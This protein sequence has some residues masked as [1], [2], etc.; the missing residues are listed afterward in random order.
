MTDSSALDK[1]HDLEWGLVLFFYVSTLIS[2]EF[3]KK[4]FCRYLN[5]FIE[6]SPNPAGLGSWSLGGDFAYLVLTGLT[7]GRTIFLP[8]FLVLGEHILI[9]FL[10]MYQAHNH[11]HRC[12][13]DPGQ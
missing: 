4:F 11:A 3:P 1:W 6:A 5:V 10:P 12:F 13:R 9:T 8:H 2:F 7:L